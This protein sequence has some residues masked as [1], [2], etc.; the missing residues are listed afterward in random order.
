MQEMTRTKK[1][2]SSK[3]YAGQAIHFIGAGGCGMSGLAE[4]ALREGGQVGGSDMKA[5]SAT[6][7][8]VRLGAAIHIGHAAE[9][10][11]PGTDLV[12][13]SAAVKPDNPERVEAGRRGI[14]ALKYARFL[15]RLMNLRQ[16]IAVSGTHGKST[17]TSMV[18]YVLAEAGLDPSFVIGAEVPQLGGGSRVGRGPHLVVEACEYDRSFLN[19]SP[20]AAA[21]LNVEEDH[22]DYYRDLR[23]IRRAFGDFAARIAADG[24]L[25]IYARDLGRRSIERRARC[26]VEKFGIGGRWDWHA[27]N[28]EADR[29]RFA[30][31]VYRHSDFYVH[32]K[33]GLAGRHNVLNA[34]A[35][36]ALCTWA[37][38]PREA[39]AEALG[40][41]QGALRRMEILG[42]AGGV[43]VV[44]DYAHHPTEIEATLKAARDRFEPRRLW[45]VFQPHQHSRTRFFLKDFARALT[46]ADKIVVPDIY[47]VRDSEKERQA[48]RSQDLVAEIQNLGAD[49]LHIKEFD[50]IRRYLVESLAAGDVLM[51]MGAG[52]V[53]RLA[54]PVLADLGGRQAAGTPCAA[55]GAGT[56]RKVR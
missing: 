2:R 3:P 11:P 15:G 24:L 41:F 40:S 43:T 13:Y 8:L 44:D 45:V 1:H 49:A 50:S 16:G 30:F 47:F 23:E 52:D 42:E 33:L 22:L 39:I 10:V 35:A 4:F 51:T 14:P 29:G 17:T 9:N 18:S 54:S 27:E 48:V 7:R 37:G 38:A 6:D 19:Y 12:V 32:V 53:W 20:R 25:V 36:M 21:V 56:R 28:L 34:L 31:D 26:K 46:V 55:A 5:S